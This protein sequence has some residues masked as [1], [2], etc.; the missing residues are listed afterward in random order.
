MAS[1]CTTEP[2]AEG[3]EKALESQF[4]ELL[5]R[6]DIESAAKRHEEILT[7]IRDKLVAA[8]FTA[9]WREAEDSSSVSGCQSG[10][11][12]TWSEIDSDTAEIRAL[13]QWISSGN[14]PDGKWEQAVKVVE[15]VA[16][17][18]GFDGPAVVVD[19]P[20][21]HEVSFKDGY[22]AHL[23]FGTVQNTVLSLTTGCHLTVAAHQRGTPT[24]K[25]T[26]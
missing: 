3:K 5:K 8:G 11:S 7:K 26:Y 17:E 4:A 15:E 25:R 16:R 21:D 2:T 1:G 20:G 12:D 24:S 6:P 9:A 22:G 14:L 19:R 10:F 23:Q 18:H 13:A